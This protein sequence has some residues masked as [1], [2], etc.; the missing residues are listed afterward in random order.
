VIPRIF[1]ALSGLVWLP[2]GIFCFFQPGYLEQAAGIVA[3]TATGTIELRAMYGGLQAGFGAFALVAALR[4]AFVRPAL[5]AACFLFA[6]LATARLLGSIAVGELSPYTA[7]ALCFEWGSLAIAAWLLRRPS[8]MAAASA[9][10][11]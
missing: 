10:M 4:A 3:T 2:Y 11:R 7:F 8:P 5:I 1:L 6:G 9:Q